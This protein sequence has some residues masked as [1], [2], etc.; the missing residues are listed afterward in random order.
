MGG[1]VA[2]D[3]NSITGAVFTQFEVTSRR[4]RRTPWMSG[5]HES[6]PRKADS[7]MELLS[8]QKATLATETA[9]H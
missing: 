7:I 5:G 2:S 3:G 4:C 9:I 1:A 8:L 6:L